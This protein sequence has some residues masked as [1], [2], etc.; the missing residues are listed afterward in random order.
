MELEKAKR[1]G[2]RILQLPV[3]TE[4]LAGFSTEAAVL[5]GEAKNKR[6]KELYVLTSAMTGGL[7]MLQVL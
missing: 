3:C 1:L 2:K 5:R 6:A 4:E 7:G